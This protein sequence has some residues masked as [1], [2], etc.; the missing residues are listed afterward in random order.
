MAGPAAAPADFNPFAAAGLVQQPDGTWASPTNDNAPSLSGVTTAPAPQLVPGQAA[1]ADIPTM[2]IAAPK[3]PAAAPGPVAT[4][5][6]G[7]PGGHVG[8][9][10]G[11]VGVPAQTTAAPQATTEFNPFAAAGLVQL[12]DGTWGSPTAAPASTTATPAPGFEAQEVRDYPLADR[13]TDFLREADNHVRQMTSSGVHGFSGGLDEIL[14]PAIPAII[15]HLTNAVPFDQAYTDA[16]NKMRAP[17]EEFAVEHP[18]EAMSLELLGSVGGLSKLT[19]P[20]FAGVPGVAGSVAKGIGSG[21][22]AATG[23]ALSP[24]A[25][26]RVQRALTYAGNIA[27]SAA[28]GGALGFLQTPG[29]VNQRIEGAQS[30]A[31]LGGLIP[32]G[33]GPAIK[34]GK[35]AYKLAN[36]LSIVGP[37]STEIMR[38]LAGLKPGEAVPARATP[39]LPEMPLNSGE[40][41]DNAGLA[42]E[43]NRLNQTDPA[44]LAAHQAAQSASI[45]SAA[46][47]R[48][49]LGVQLASGAM[50]PPEASAATANALRDARDTFRAEAQRLWNRPTI[51]G[52]KPD[53]DL[54]HASV[55]RS[56][57]ALPASH[58]EVIGKTPELGAALRSLDT[59]PDGAS[60]ADVNYVRSELLE[61]ER[62]YRR[63]QPYVAK[64]AGEAAAA[65]L[66]G[67]ESNPALRANPRAMVDYERARDFTRNVAQAMGFKAFRDMVQAAETGTNI[68]GVANGLF[69][70]GK[71]YEVNPQGVSKVDD[72]LKGVQKSWADLKTANAGVPVS[73]TNNGVTRTLDPSVPFGART[74]LTQ[75]AR[76]FITN[77]F[78]D[79]TLSNVTGVGNQGL[80]RLNQLQA[81]IGRNRAWMRDSGLFSNDQMNL[82]DRI[83][84]AAI[85][86]ARVNNQR[87]P[88]SQTFRLLAGDKYLDGILGASLGKAW[89]PAIGAATAA[90]LTHLFGET[91]L[92]SWLGLAEMGVG[93]MGGRL[94]I[95]PM[96]ESRFQPARDAIMAKVREAMENPRIAADLMKERGAKVSDATKAWM[97]SFAALAP[98]AVASIPEPAR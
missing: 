65:V 54:L 14:L 71:G 81:D 3:L 7:V 56:I 19:A 42:A 26:G 59:L 88:G 1:P 83:Q 5:P 22:T 73:I 90:T 77:S 87:S 41:F 50:R 28:T 2:H 66:R 78:L 32:V 21:L 91:G 36:P 68:G 55:T 20:I 35:A 72:L 61:I 13:F 80:Q 51:T 96:L 18:N 16:V 85:V 60:L 27:T 69:N 34:M 79:R 23:R 25:M 24:E 94:G 40:A 44:L 15:N 38:E 46:T 75:G 8:V 33:A 62:S 84:Q 52:V 49:P 95:Q 31:E 63:T 86:G 12:P 11:H 82:W 53:M 43:Q 39:L 97:R 98:G 10:G 89:G 70:F 6:I 47:T 64:V 58:R 9:P 76:D 93:M 57:E 92:A 45:Q 74:D 37:K 48:Q 4:P 17:R 29:D 30:G 67:I